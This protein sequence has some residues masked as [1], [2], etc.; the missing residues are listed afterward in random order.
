MALKNKRHLTVVDDDASVR[1]ALENLIS[2]I[3]HDVTVFASAAAFLNSNALERTDCIVLDLRL[4]GM[5]GLELQQKLAAEGQRIPVVM[6]TAHAD[7]KTR[8]EA[9][10]A[11]AIAFI[12][13]PFKEEVL[14]AAIESALKRRDNHNSTQTE[15]DTL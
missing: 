11:G 7:D 2:S 12:K 3:G 5:N 9:I 13:K 1:E 14:L 6:I 10:T 4:P 8:A 15:G